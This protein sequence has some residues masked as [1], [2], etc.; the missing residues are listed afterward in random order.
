MGDLVQKILA[1]SK[2]IYEKLGTTQKIIIGAACAAVVLVFILIV[3]S[4]SSPELTYL[5][6][7]PL[8]MEDYAR[9]T[10]NLQEYGANFST[11]EDRYVL[12]ADEET[13]MK[14]RM[15]LGQD[16]ILPQDIKGWELFDTEKWTTTDFERNI[17]KRRAIIGSIT[18]HIK[19][20][21]DVEDVSITVSMPEGSLYINSD[22][23]WKASVTL[24]AA[25]YSDLY[26]NEKKIKGIIQ[27]VVNGIDKLKEENIV[28]TDN[29]GNILSD[30][31]EDAKSDYLQLAK[32][33]RKIAEKARVELE[34]R[35]RGKLREALGEDRFDLSITYE[36]DFDQ[37]SIQKN[38]IIPIV[39]KEDNPDTPYDE[40]QNTLFVDIS[41]K[42]VDEKFKGPA[43]IP[44]GPAGT[45][46]NIPPGMK[47]IV[48]R[49]T[50]YE[51]NENIVN[52][53]VSRQQI[54]TK[55]AS[56]ITKRISVAAWIDGKWRMIRDKD[57]NIVMTEE[58]SIKRE[59]IPV[60]DAELREYNAILR[61][62]ISF[63]AAR[64]DQVTVRHLQFDRSKEHEAEDEAVRA[65]E[66]MRKILI[67]SVS[68]IFVLFV[69][70]IAYRLISKELARRRRIREEELA[71]QQQRMREQALRAAEEEGVEVE[72]SLEEKA[73]LEMQ[74][75]AVNIA[76]ERP[77]DVAAL[78][79]TWLME[80]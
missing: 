56:Y 12:V 45:E 11:R 41:Q 48:N 4:S 21:E 3:S 43:F 68:A 1:Q 31:S 55:R 5:F 15:R 32:E 59:Y 13:G 35:L 34:T 74:E 44:E 19:T 80:E 77:E 73:R 65:K 40:S 24:I 50:E 27:L 70:T 71:L 17:T 42:T 16:N 69:G 36:L 38:E 60:T 78:V 62:A 6:E 29:K 53:D 66:R 7:R 10:K 9:I 47:E 61:G 72:L 79:R 28:V 51:K 26:T 49:K 18:R 37:T 14:L 54:Q 2:A 20:L 67:A 52:R 25:P 63:N 76:R 33:E 58:K 30:F 64:G 46:N 57:G 8:S 39:L 23:P 75:N 22:D